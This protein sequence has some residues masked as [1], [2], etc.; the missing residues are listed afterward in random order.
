MKQI[1]LFKVYMSDSAD[2]K[3]SQVLHSGMVS[4]GE[5][6][7]KYETALQKHFGYPYIL[8]V[9]S[10]TSGLTLALRMLD[11]PL[12]S[13]I[14]CTPLTCAA[15]NFAV[16]A[17]RYRIR[18]V[19]I[20]PNTCNMDMNALE[21]SITPESRAI[22][23]VH[24]GGNPIDMSRLNTIRDT[25]NIPIIEDCA[26]AFGAKHLSK[27]IG[28]WSNLS[29]FSTQAI[30]HLT[31]GDGGFICLPNHNMYKRVKKLRWFGIDRE[32]TNDE[33]YRLELDIQEWGYKFHMN[34]INASIGLCNLPDVEK[35]I[36]YVRNKVKKY[37]SCFDNMSHIR[38][39]GQTGQAVNAY[40][41]YTLFVPGR[42]QFIRYMKR[43][44]IVTSQVHR[45][46]DTYTTIQ[47]FVNNLDEP[48]P[49]LEKVSKTM[50]C[51]P[52][53]WWMTDRDYQ[54]VTY[55][56]LKWNKMLFPQALTSDKELHFP[57]LSFL[58]K[59]Y[60][61]DYSNTII[62]HISGIVY[63]IC[64][65]ERVIGM[66]TL[67]IDVKVGDNVGRVEDVL[68]DEEWR[69]TGIATILVQ[70][71]IQRSKEYGCY[72]LVLGAK[73]NLNDLYTKQGFVREGGLYTIRY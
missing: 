40:W 9:N 29:V 44:G 31:T 6:V 45:R 42:K 13:E 20:D 58:S 50:V 69:R 39:F 63:V 71:I 32:Q 53:G 7:E 25:Y 16:L 8:S 15:T 62:Q 1:P 54:H 19:D 11:L 30:K 60:D 65:E 21:R 57:Y 68:V 12:H 4:Q 37:Y 48:L 61:K 27:R 67:V 5:V 66:A 22:L 49:N 46:N 36:E 10:A 3:V 70:H 24:W 18:W 41:I 51:I 35:N 26:H 59:Y 73:D 38:P 2:R 72:K 43:Q 55:H 34:D 64:I 33:D 23:V 52:C 14:L 56:V 28:T 47:P 17:N